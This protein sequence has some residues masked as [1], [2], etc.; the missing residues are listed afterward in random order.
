LSNPLDGDKVAILERF[1]I[2]SGL[3]P[4]S[5]ESIAAI[6]LPKK[7]AKKDIL[8]K[9]GDTAR[10]FYLLVSG[11]VKLG[12]ISPSGKEQILHFVNAGNSFAEAAIYMDRKYPAMAEAL[13]ESHLLFIPVDAFTRLLSENSDLAVNLV[14]HLAS[15]LHMLTR[16]V[17]E[18]SLMDA[19]ARL[20]RYLLGRMDR[21]TGLVRLPEGKGHTATS[22][23]MAVE[24]FSR[25]LARFKEAEVLREASPG[26]LQVLDRDALEA[27]TV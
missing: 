2:F 6:A 23:G 11:R 3:D 24:T 13:V 20:G 4:G 15:Y 10:G 8:F 16:K 22:L 5:L 27:Y 9:E 12:K 21:D 19:A 14:A 1:P 17:E 25:T 26:V 18:L 7:I